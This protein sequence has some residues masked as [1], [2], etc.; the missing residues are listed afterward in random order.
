MDYMGLYIAEILRRFSYT[1]HRAFRH[2]GRG[3]SAVKLIDS[4]PLRRCKPTLIRRTR[5]AVEIPFLFPSCRRILPTVP[6]AFF[7]AP[8]HGPD[9]ERCRGRRCR[10]C[11]Q[12]GAATA[13]DRTPS[14]SGRFFHGSSGRRS[15]L[16]LLMSITFSIIVLLQGLLL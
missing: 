10:S 15:F 6:L 12:D 7:V 11:E 5:K 4:L 2:C 8:L 13:V 1:S 14:I 3:R 16:F 9:S